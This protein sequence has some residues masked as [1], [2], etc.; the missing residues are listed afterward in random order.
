V[1]PVV[2]ILVLTGCQSV[3]V[4]PV[5]ELTPQARIE[6]VLIIASGMQQQLLSGARF[7][8]QIQQAFK[9]AGIDTRLVFAEGI[10]DEAVVRAAAADFRPTH[11]LLL[12]ILT[13]TQDYTGMV[14]G[15]RLTAQLYEMKGGRAIWHATLDSCGS[16]GSPGATGDLVARR[17]VEKMRADGLW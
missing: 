9:D 17:L 15:F 13:I 12:N 8:G 2:V 6:H 11:Q 10:R 4:S 14:T 16:S 1:T 3:T 5:R 7:D